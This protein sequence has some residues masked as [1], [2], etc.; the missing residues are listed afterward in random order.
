MDLRFRPVLPPN[1]PRALPAR[2]LG[3]HD[4]LESPDALVEAAKLD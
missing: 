2:E 1:M 3:S 4:I